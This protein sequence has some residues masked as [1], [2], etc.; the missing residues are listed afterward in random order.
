MVFIIIIY[1]SLILQI[2][3]YRRNVELISRYTGIN[4]EFKILAKF[5]TFDV[6]QIIF[7]NINQTCK[8]FKIESF[9][10]SLLSS[11]TNL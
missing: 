5:I 8:I 1:N 10:M 4:L 2:K 9:I 6:L 11:T 7:H 3:I